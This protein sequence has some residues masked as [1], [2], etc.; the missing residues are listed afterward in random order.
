MTASY[1][2]TTHAWDGDLVV[3]H[4]GMVFRKPH[5]PDLVILCDLSTSVSG[6]SRFT[7]L[8]VQALAGQFRRVRILGFVNRVAD[9]TDEVLGAA[10]GSDLSGAFDDLSRM[11]RWHR[12][13]DYGAVLADVVENHLDAIGHRTAVL[14]LGDA[15]S[16]HTDP[17]LDLLR[18]IAARARHVSWLNPEPSRMWG[19]GDSVALRYAEIVDMHE[20]RNLA[21][22][23]EF[24]ARL[25]PV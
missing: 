13:S 8:L 19:S 1:S 11:T 16:N 17:Q 23:R 14:V 6:F 18:E 21:Q 7:I 2:R 25:L 3:F 9:L 10:P 5:R 15:R 4:I 22:L 12:N 24:V 20:C